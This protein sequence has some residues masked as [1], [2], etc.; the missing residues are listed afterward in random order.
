MGSKN[1]EVGKLGRH[2]VERKLTIF[3]LRFVMTSNDSR[4]VI[5]SSSAA[6]NQVGKSALET[7]CKTSE[8]NKQRWASTRGRRCLSV[9]KHVTS[10]Y[11]ISLKSSQVQ[12]MDATIKWVPL[13][14]AT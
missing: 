10:A 7:N 1:V 14:Q 2:F 3:P 8:Q 13:K 4:D 6:A 11:Q 12:H 5:T 9:R